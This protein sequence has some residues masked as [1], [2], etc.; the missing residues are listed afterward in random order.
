MVHR[1]L[2]SSRPDTRR[3]HTGFLLTCAALAAVFLPGAIV[4]RLAAATDVT[5]GAP[6][7]AL[8]LRQLDGQQ[9]NL[10]SLRGRVVVLNFW[11]TWCPPCRT[12][13]LMFD[14]FARQYLDRGVTVVAVSIDD[15]RNRRD[16]ERIAANASFPVGLQAEASENGFA[17]PSAL[18]M[19]YL[20]DR[21]GM[22]RAL[23][24]PGRRALTGADLAA[25]V[26]PL[27]GSGHT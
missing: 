10:E 4:G 11:A 26:A 13:L 3:R 7:P 23:L 9:L 2:Q 1:Q 19:T 14:K 22:V 21:E 6:V 12:E 18:P 24:P 17:T 25:K 16:V 5:V 20:I 27:L 15:P 8:V